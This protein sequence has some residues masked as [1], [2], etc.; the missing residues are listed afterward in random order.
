M[1]PRKAFSTRG[2]GVH[3]DKLASF[4]LALRE[5]GIEKFN[6]VCVSSILPPNCKLVTTE[7]G[8]ESLSPGEIVYCVLSRN[9]TNE[10]HRLI[11]SAVGTAIPLNKQNY[12]Y[13]SEYHSFGE[14]ENTAGIYAEDIAASMLATTRGIE[15]DADSTWQDREQ[16]YQASGHIFNTYHICRTARGDKGGLWTTVVAAIVFVE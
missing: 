8:L 5:A 6:L 9:Q 7:E 16:I 10:P 2:T 1:I 4:E 11:A 14:D 3:R 13:I 15:L 12:G